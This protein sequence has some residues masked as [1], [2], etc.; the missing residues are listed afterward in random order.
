MKK[1]LFFRFSILSFSHFHTFFFIF[2]SNFVLAKKKKHSPP[3]SC[4]SPH[5]TS[6][7]DNVLCP[8]CLTSY[9]SGVCRQHD[10]T[11]HDHASVCSASP[12]KVT[13]KHHHCTKCTKNH[14]HVHACYDHNS[15]HGDSTS[16]AA[17]MAS[18]ILSV[19]PRMNF[20]RKRSTTPTVNDRPTGIRQADWDMFKET[21]TPGITLVI[22]ATVPL[23]WFSL[24]GLVVD[25]TKPAMSIDS[26]KHY[27]I[28]KN[29]S[30]DNLVRMTGT[31]SVLNSQDGS[32]TSV[33]RKN[34]ISVG[35]AFDQS[36]TG[37]GIKLDSSSSWSIFRD[38][39]HS[40]K[41]N[42]SNVFF[43]ATIENTPKFE[44]EYRFELVRASDLI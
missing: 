14:V 35:Y 1:E 10:L 11:D 18:D 44:K 9:C 2:S 3:M 38:T 8:K 30:D 27:L 7:A 33:I 21:I 12:C 16:C 32:I 24:G 22:V 29:Q 20:L 36:G 40:I 15:C 17:E 25:D 43:P 31:F 34:G 41:I 6:K 37:L 39:A 23:Q 4:H 28:D 42:G 13:H 26:L 19:G 5:C